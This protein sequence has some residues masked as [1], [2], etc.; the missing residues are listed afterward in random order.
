[1]KKIRIK[2]TRDESLWSRI[3]NGNV[4]IG[5]AAPGADLA[6]SFS[7]T[8]EYDIAHI[9]GNGYRLLVRRSG[10][11]SGYGIQAQDMTDSGFTNAYPQA[12]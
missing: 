9:D 7:S 1:M 11:A 2:I 4:G 3:N 5:T 8:G 6:I 10:A 12:K